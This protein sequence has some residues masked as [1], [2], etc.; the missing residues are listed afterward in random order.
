MGVDNCLF[1]TTE[2]PIDPRFFIENKHDAHVA[3]EW[4]DFVFAVVDYVFQS[5]HTCVPLSVVSFC[6]LLSV[7]VP[8]RFLKIDKFGI[9]GIIVPS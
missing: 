2:L 4:L 8:P 5:F 7:E 3:N 6:W 1:R 9:V